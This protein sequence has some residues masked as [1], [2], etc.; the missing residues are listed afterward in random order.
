[1]QA[2]NSVK[3]CLSGECKKL[4]TQCALVLK[5]LSNSIKEMTHSS[6]LDLLVCDMNLAIEDIRDALRSLPSQ[7]QDETQLQQ[8]SVPSAITT[9]IKTQ[10]LV[11]MPLMEVLPVITVASLLIEI[12]VRIEGV[13][14]AVET[15]ANLSGFKSVSDDKPEK[16]SSL[17]DDG[18]AAAQG[19]E[20]KDAIQVV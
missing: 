9:T 4:G 11:N 3:K 7:L 18:A 14:D 1:L 6:S 15:L 13:V 20:T 19:T 8:H 12:S 10:N 5:E 17:D 2:S 16:I